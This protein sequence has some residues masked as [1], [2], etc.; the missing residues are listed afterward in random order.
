MNAASHGF[1]ASAT[2]RPAAIAALAA[3]CESLGYDSFWL[4]VAGALQGARRPDSG[5]PEGAPEWQAVGAQ[6]P[7]DMLAAAIDATTTITI[8]IGLAPI[9]VFPP[10][11]LI[12]AVKRRSWPVDRAIL[13]IAAGASGARCA[14]RMRAALGELREA[15]LPVRLGS[16]GRGPLVLQ[17]SGATADAICLAWLTPVGLAD[18]LAHIASGADAAGRPAPP[19]Y[20]YVRIG[21]GEGGEERVRVEMSRYARL[22]H[23]VDN[24]DALA[25]AELIG[26]AIESPV[27]LAAALARYWQAGVRPVVRPVLAGA[28]DPEAWE[29]AARSL[30]P[31]VPRTGPVTSGTTTGGSSRDG[32]AARP[33]G[34]AGA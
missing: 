4:N 33:S 8:G 26:A 7:V 2:L 5:V 32:D 27:D 22:P 1:G 17:A 10:A 11:G 15:R 14:S 21:L 34:A 29:A 16:G 24:R 9:D 6:H 23:H 20:P 3:T 13:G 18:A 30:A 25:K 19:V 28:G 31:T 12:E